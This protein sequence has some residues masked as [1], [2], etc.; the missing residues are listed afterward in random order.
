VFDHDTKEAVLKPG[1]INAQYTFYLTNVSS[2]EVM[3][4]A[5]RPSCGC[6]VANLP[7]AP[8]RLAPGAGGPISATMNVA[9]KPGTMIKTL[10]VETSHG[11]KHLTLRAVVPDPSVVASQTGSGLNIQRANN[12]ALAQANR[13]LTLKGECA[14]CHV[15][16]AKDKVGRDL[17]V[18]ACGIC[19]HA[20]HRASVVADL[21]NLKAEPTPEFWRQHITLGKPGTLMP[22]FAHEAGGFLS[23]AQVDSLV[24]YLIKEFPKEG[25]IVYQGT[26]LG[27][28]KPAS[29]SKSATN[30]I[31][32]ASL[33]AS[34]LLPSGVSAFPVPREP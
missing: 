9:G 21:Q 27:R 11:Q 10:T 20:E 29:N 14:A 1:E 2:S 30:G 13:Q 12:I 24:A 8:W 17:Y 3:V 4:H 33:R 26:L 5:L 34:E 28:E 19:H 16:P 32:S 18:A 6:T 25:K 22:A 7:E 31:P 23:K 15:E